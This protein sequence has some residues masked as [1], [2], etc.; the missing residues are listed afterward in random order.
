MSLLGS[1]NIEKIQKLNL[2]SNWNQSDI[3]KY[4]LENEGRFQKLEALVLSSLKNVNL[5]QVHKVFKNLVIM[6]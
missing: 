2:A 6:N 1:K 3:V 5:E 4:L